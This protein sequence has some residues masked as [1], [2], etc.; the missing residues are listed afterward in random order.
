MSH[1]PTW[2]KIAVLLLALPLG[3]AAC[4]HDPGV[5]VAADEY[6]A[7]PLN[8]GEYVIRPGDVLN[9]RVFQQDNMSARARVRSDGKISLPF[10]NDVTAAGFTPPVLGAQL[11][12]RLKD[13]INN[14]VVTVSLEEVRL[15]S[16]SVLGEVPRPGI[17]PLEVGAGVLQALAAAGGFTNFAYR[18]IFVMRPMPTGEKPLRIRFDYER[19]SRADGKGAT[20]LLRSGDIVIVE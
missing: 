18:D 3:L 10:L 4:R 14:P 16:V 7:P 11:Q 1:E 6:V 20:F 17:Y 15:L 12:T 9:V 8:E 19:V 5:Y 2:P 13:F